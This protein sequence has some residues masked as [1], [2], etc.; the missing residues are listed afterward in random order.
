VAAVFCDAFS[1]DACD[2]AINGLRFQL[3]KPSQFEFHFSQCSN[4]VRESFFKTVSHENF[5]YAGFVVHKRKL[6]G[7]RFR[8]PKQVYEFS[9]SIV[10]EQVKSLLDNSKI[11]IDRNG[12]RVF[13]ARLEKSLKRQ[14]TDKDGSCKIKKVTMESSH[15][16]NLIQLADMLC[17]ALN[18]SCTSGDD[19]FRDLVRGKEKFVQNW[20]N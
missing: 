14:M 8:D 18:R 10:C 3:G 2:R 6:F 19:K 17:G 7:E 5:R 1:A 9:V 20:P 4:R 11:I 12:D 16:N 15:S 13:K